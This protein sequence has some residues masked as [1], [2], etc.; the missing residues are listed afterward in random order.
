MFP[1]FD[2]FN[3]DTKL[4]KLYEFNIKKS[5]P[6]NKCRF[7]IVIKGY[8][9]STRHRQPAGW[10]QLLRQDFLQYDVFQACEPTHHL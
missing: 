9:S 1:F 6:N 4:K 3:N 2:L 7:F 10:Q 5:A 8:F